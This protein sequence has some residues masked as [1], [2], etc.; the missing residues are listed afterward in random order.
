M[1]VGRGDCKPDPW[2]SWLIKKQSDFK[3]HITIPYIFLQT[4]RD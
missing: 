3:E 4:L 2:L 1:E